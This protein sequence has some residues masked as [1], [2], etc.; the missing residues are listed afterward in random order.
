MILFLRSSDIGIDARLRR[1]ARALA[2]S[3]I[4]HAALFWDRGEASVSETGIRAIR[5]RAPAGYASRAGTG[6]RLIGLNLFALRRMWRMRREL[7]LVHAV[8]LDTAA[9]A[10]ALRLLAGVP[11]V[12]DIY[13]SYPDS[14]GLT[15]WVRRPFDWLERKVIARAAMV[16]IADECRVAQHQPIPPERLMI[17]EN[18]PDAPRPDRTPTA[19][20]AA[21]RIAYLGTLEARYRGLEDMLALVEEREELEFDIGG[22]G[23]LESLVREAAARCPRIRFHGP[24]AHDAGLAMMGRCDLILGLYY[25]DVPNHRFAAPNKYFEHLLLGR[26]LLTS[27]HTPPGDKVAAFATGW[28]SDDG[29]QALSATLDAMLADRAQLRLRGENAARLWDGQFAD[30]FA[31][32]IAGDYVTAVQRH[33]RAAPESRHRSTISAIA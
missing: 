2:P 6:L 16:I 25:A 19:P 33:A 15:G 32:A 24:M 21:L 10:L 12:Y 11:Y 13:D 5:Y 9:S 14:R 8:D 23:A 22:A 20:G 31:R 30:Y 3:G 7:T 27:T 17:V 4:A 18:V 26:P 1:Y 29:K 28:A